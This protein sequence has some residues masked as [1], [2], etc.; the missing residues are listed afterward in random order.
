[1]SGKFELWV[2]SYCMSKFIKYNFLFI[3]NVIVNFLPIISIHSDYKRAN[4]QN[5][6]SV[7][8]G[9]FTLTTL[10]IKPNYLVNYSPLT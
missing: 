8:N 10:L 2:V 7:Y 4:T 9:L 6:K 3:M 5:I 1:M